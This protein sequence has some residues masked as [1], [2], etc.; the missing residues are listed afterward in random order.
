MSYYTR[1]TA[2]NEIQLD[3]CSLG[4]LFLLILSV[5]PVSVMFY[6]GIRTYS[7]MTKATSQLSNHM[8]LQRELFQAL[9]IQST[10]PCIFLFIPSLIYFIFPIFNL[11]LG[12][13]SNIA[14]ITFVIYPVLDLIA[15]IYVI[16]HYRHFVF[17]LLCLS[18]KVMPKAETAEKEEAEVKID[19]SNEIYMS[20]NSI[21]ND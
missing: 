18:H 11:P 17:K 2:T 1:N 10:V 9:L 16:K 4:C 8:K 15:V 6:C 7:R 3:L 5:T 19:G 14:G 21:P 20:F 12:L 13:F